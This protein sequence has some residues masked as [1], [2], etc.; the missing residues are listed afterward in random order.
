M[1]SMFKREHRTPTHV[2][3]LLFAATRSRVQACFL[4]PAAAVLDGRENHTVLGGAIHQIGARR[5]E[6]PEAALLREAHEEMGC[7]ADN[8]HR[9]LRI[10]EPVLHVTGQGEQKTTQ[11]FT[12]IV[13]E[14]C[15]EPRFQDEIAE[16]AWCDPSGWFEKIASMNEGKQRM[17]LH[18]MREAA[19]FRELFP[20]IRRSLRS[21]LDEYNSQSAMV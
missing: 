5:F 8:W 10:G 16:V 9:Y 21:F 13:Y 4:K 7:P 12:G 3:G 20:C 11:L 19:S 15:F 2:A 1:G 18:M 6:A 14:P 17:V